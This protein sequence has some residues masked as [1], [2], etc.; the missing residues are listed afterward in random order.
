MSRS[1]NALALGAR[2]G[3]L[4][5]RKPRCRTV[6]SRLFEKILVPIVDQEPVAV[7]AGDRVTQLLGRP[8]R[9][10]VGRDVVVH[11]PPAADFHYDEHVE[12][13]KRGGHDGQEIAGH[14]RFGVVADKRQPALVV[15]AATCARAK[16]LRPILSHYARRDAQAELEEQLIG[17]TFLAP[18]GVVPC[19]LGDQGAEVS[20]QGRPPASAALPPPQQ[21]EA[22][23]M[24]ADHRRRLNNDNRLAPGAQPGLRGRFADGLEWTE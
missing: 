6:S 23:P 8:R 7:I 16:L 3:L 13:A 4:R 21:L 17:D 24:P 12:H 10:R 22:A 2:T 19:H 11:D 5:T 18:G 15:R 14:D 1:Q 9:R 20:R